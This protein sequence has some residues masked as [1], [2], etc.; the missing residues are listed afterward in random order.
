MRIL[1]FVALRHIEITPAY[2]APSFIAFLN[3]LSLLVT[4]SF[5]SC[6]YQKI[7]SFT[8]MHIKYVV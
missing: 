3:L 7:Q 6:F 4:F 5:Q 2:H 8:E 1:C